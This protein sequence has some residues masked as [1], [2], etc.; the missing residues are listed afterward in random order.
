MLDVFSTA[1]REGPQLRSERLGDIGRSAP[2]QWKVPAKDAQGHARAVHAMVSVYT[3]A[4]E[5]TLDKGK[6]KV[7]EC[8]GGRVS[9]SFTCEAQAIGTQGEIHFGYRDGIGQPR[10][11][12]VETKGAPSIRPLTPTGDLLLGPRYRN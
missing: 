7:H 2:S 6:S 8:T 3:N 11:A 1:F 5:A 12:A 10:F 4:D 9:E